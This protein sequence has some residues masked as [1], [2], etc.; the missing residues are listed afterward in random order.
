MISDLVSSPPRFELPDWHSR[1]IPNWR[2]WLAPYIGRDYV[3]ALEIG[4]C[5]GRSALWLLENVLTG[6]VPVLWCVDPFKEDGFVEGQAGGVSAERVFENFNRN[7]MSRSWSRHIREP[8]SVALKELGGSFDIGYVDGCHLAKNVLEDAILAWPLLKVGGTLIFD[9]YEWTAPSGD[10]FDT[11][12]PAI[13]TFLSF[14]REELEIL[15]DVNGRLKGI[16][17]AVRKTR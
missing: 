1:H 17:V 9:D 14:Y 10:L 13:E 16:Q 2:G 12:K 7:V 8:S 4:S 6:K 3:R 11:P 15:S 5:E